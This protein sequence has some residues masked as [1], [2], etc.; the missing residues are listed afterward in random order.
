MTIGIIGIIIALALFMLLV[1]KGISS[2]IV[3]PVCAIIVAVTN[4]MGAVD[5]F[6]TF[7]QGLGEMIIQLFAIIFLGVVLG[8]VYTETKAAASIAKTLTTKFIVK[9]QGNAQVRIAI[10]IMLIIAGAMTLGGI[11]G[12][13]LTFTTFPIAFIIAEMV[14][15]P[16]KYIPAMLM[17]NCAFMACPGAPQIDNIAMV[18][19]LTK[20]GYDVSSTSGLVPGLI[21]VAVVIILG[22]LTLTTMIIKSKKN[23]EHF[24]P[25][26][27][28]KIDI[29]SE[30]IKLPNFWIALIPLILVFL[31]YSVAKLDV[32]IALAAGNIAAL[33]LMGRYIDRKDGSLLKGLIK[34]INDGAGQY[35]HALAT[36][37]TPSGLATVVTS[38]AAFGAIVGALSTLSLHPVLL[39]L[40]TIC[41]IVALTSAPPVALYVGLPIVVGIL[42]S[43]GID[44]NVHGL[45]RVAALSATTFESLPVN[46]MCV[47]TIGLARTSYKES[48]LPM[49]LNTVVYTFAASLLCALIY[50]IAPGLN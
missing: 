23:G 25:G 49:F 9:H 4:S 37:S 44:F 48:Y 31:L 13:V 46:G 33:I 1:Y 27:I 30:N 10:L 20:E 15:I 45:G 3:A 34:T 50:I 47:L 16:R 36:V 5:T 17:L 43:K 8:K 28:K 7:A 32:A 19:A 29:F 12:F 35:P 6:Y 24:D 41:V 38:T 14:D 22:Y 42:A 21:A 40:L 2:F 26:D 11:D 18:G 39:G